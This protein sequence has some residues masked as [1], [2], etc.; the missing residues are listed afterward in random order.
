MLLGA[1]TDSYRLSPLLTALIPHQDL[2]AVDKIAPL[3]LTLLTVLNITHFLQQAKPVTSLHTTCNTK[4]LI[5]MVQCN[6]CHLQYIGETKRRLKDR[7]NE[8]RRT[9]DKT[10][11]SS[12]PT[13]VSEHFLSHP[14]HC[15]TDMQLIPLEVIHSSRDSIRKARESFLIDLAGTLEPHGLNRRDEL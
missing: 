9:V 11:I 6:R 15:H 4:N 8:H 3:V 13:T 10:N 5:Y 2:S 12:K 1:A 14:N 7:F